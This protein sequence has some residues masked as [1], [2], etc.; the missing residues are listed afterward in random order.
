MHAAE[1]YVR[2]KKTHT[3]ILYPV[4]LLALPLVRA[5]NAASAL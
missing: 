5:P 1:D 3:M 4:V 2:D